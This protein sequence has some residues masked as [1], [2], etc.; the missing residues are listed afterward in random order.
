M[1]T[2]RRFQLLSG[3]SGFSPVIDFWMLG[4]L[5]A[6]DPQIPNL[7]L[8]ANITIPWFEAWNPPPP[9]AISKVYRFAP[10]IVGPL[11]QLSTTPVP[12]PPFDWFVTFGI[13]APS[14][15]GPASF[16]V[17]ILNP[18]NLPA[19]PFDWYEQFG[20]PAPS[21]K[22]TEGFTSN[23]LSPFNLPAPPFGW[24]AQNDTP[25]SKAAL[26]SDAFV[27]ALFSPDRLQ[28]FG[29][30]EQIA[31]PPVA[32]Q[33]PLTT[34]ATFVP[35]PQEQNYGWFEPWGTPQ[36]TSRRN[37]VSD[38][39]ADFVAPGTPAQPFGWFAY[40]RLPTITR[41]STALFD[42]WADNSFG[43]PG[44][45]PIV[46]VPESTL[47]G[48]LDPWLGPVSFY[49][50]WRP[51]RPVEEDIQ[52]EPAEH[53]PEDDEPQEPEFVPKLAAPMPPLR[54][55]ENVN[56]LQLDSTDETIII[57]LLL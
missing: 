52:Y 27:T 22:F 4:N 30:Y 25:K 41:P 28:N 39:I 36:F 6:M 10:S 51:T 8:E 11:D 45:V 38:V 40:W 15:K 48:G 31:R 16:T 14:V 21:V 32:A 1:S 44:P 23:V 20:K 49:N 3:T 37:A 13:P 56:K 17:N 34:T 50:K 42:T 18:F 5:T 9:S 47:G 54:Y 24:Y 29:W 12:A 53:G 57:E 43:P 55:P 7:P 35:A 26:V 2:N 19:P 33:V 46:V